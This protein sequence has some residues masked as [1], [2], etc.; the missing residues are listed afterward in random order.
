MLAKIIN[1]CQQILKPLAFVLTWK[2]ILKYTVHT[3]S[4]SI[5]DSSYGPGAWFCDIERLS[6][7]L[8]EQQT[9][10]LI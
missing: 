8:T 5:K 9:H 1:Q 7:R 6:W 3:V 2:K 4:L 10:R